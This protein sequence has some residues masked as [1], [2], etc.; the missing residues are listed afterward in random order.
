MSDTR[1]TDE[2]RL[3]VGAILARARGTRGFTIA[4][5][6]RH[7]K[8]TTEQVEALEAGAYD[9][10][11]GRVFARGF[12]RNYAKLVG[13][14]PQ[15]LLRSID[16]EM[17]GPD[18]VELRTH[19]EVVMPQEDRARWPLYSAF[20]AFVVVTLLAVYEFGFNDAADRTPPSPAAAPDPATESPGSPRNAEQHEKAVD[21]AA[22][23][24]PSASET[25]L[26]RKAAPESREVQAAT[27]STATERQ[28]HMRFDQDSWVEIRDGNNKVIFSKLSRAGRQERVTGTPPFEVT[29]GNARGVRLKYEDTPIDLAPHTAMTVARLTLK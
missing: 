8:I 18:L 20:A 10:L 24:S 14:D 9:K 6:A 17:S 15:P 4:D 21:P 3:T 22:P 19:S 16:G 25:V 11:P 28:L 26:A 27:S 12:L 23:S 13:I 2:D 1:V 5:V 29:V 7:L